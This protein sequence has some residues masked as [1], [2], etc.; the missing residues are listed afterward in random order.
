[1]AEHLEEYRAKR[2]AGKT[3]EPLKTSRKRK[4]GDP[5]FIVQRHS[6]RRLH[7][8]LRLERDG[9]LLSWALPRGVPL[10]AGE[11]ALAVHVEDHPLEYADFEGEIP[12][13]QYGAGYVELWDRGTYELVRERPDGT[14]TVILHGGKLEGEWALVPAKLDGEERNWLIVRAAKDGAPGPQRAY[15]PMLPRPAKR[16]PTGSDWAFEIAWDGVRALAPMEG[17]RAHFQHDAGDELEERTRKLLGRM[18]RAVR[19]SDCVLDGVICSFD[20]GVVYVV[21]D[22]LELEGASLIDLP[23]SDRRT[24]LTGLLDDHV[25]EV[26]LSRAYDDGPALRKAARAQGLGV[27][28]KRRKSP[29]RPGV[30][31]DDWRV[32]PS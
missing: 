1:M 9:V 7:Y 31:S 25:G 13:G 6:A 8:D 29:Y 32:L 17:T 30:A 19:T 20:E 12:D 3:P 11:R 22:L 26:R 15:E 23:W 18:P 2:H 10:R 16:V 5:R 24:R 27:V 28:A 4:R 14:L 21:I